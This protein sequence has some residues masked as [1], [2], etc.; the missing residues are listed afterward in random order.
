MNIPDFGLTTGWTAS[1]YK[2][3]RDRGLGISFCW[4]PKPL[5]TGDDHFLGLWD[6]VPRLCSA[7]FTVPNVHFVRPS[8]WLQGG[9]WHLQGYWGT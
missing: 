9:W 5:L 3:D 4:T 8:L 6:S 2:N 7:P 1:G